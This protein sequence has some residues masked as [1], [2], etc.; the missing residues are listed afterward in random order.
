MYI[1]IQIMYIIRLASEVRVCCCGSSELSHLLAP[2]M[3]P[4]LLPQLCCSE[5]QWRTFN[6]LGQKFLQ[7][8]LCPNQELWGLAKANATFKF[9]QVWA[10]TPLQD[11][12]PSGGGFV[13][14]TIL[15]QLGLKSGETFKHTKSFQSAQSMPQYFP[16]KNAK[17]H[18]ADDIGAHFRHNV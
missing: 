16:H 14:K 3:L 7:K 18:P 10:A 4:A 8:E 2:G 11:Y 5:I 13:L 12:R 9:L 6:P 15:I 1:N 17:L